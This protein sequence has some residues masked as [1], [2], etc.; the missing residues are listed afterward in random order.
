MSARQSL[1]SGPIGGRIGARV[2]TESA[3]STRTTT[4][5]SKCAPRIQTLG[6]L[7]DAQPFWCNRGDI[8]TADAVLRQSKRR[9]DYARERERERERK[10]E[11]EADRKKERKK[12]REGLHQITETRCT[13]H[14]RDDDRLIENGSPVC[15]DGPRR[16]STMTMTTT[17][18]NR[19]RSTNRC[20]DPAGHHEAGP[21]RHER[22]WRMCTSRAGPDRHGTNRC[23]GN[24]RRSR[25]SVRERPERGPIS[26]EGTSIAPFP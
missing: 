18:T 8:H 26:L 1:I 5:T 14:S 21:I 19:R 22:P 17:K 11:G 24:L 16:T 23:E 13:F 2:N 6:P 15:T 25:E 9:S 10:R 3:A 20:T 7:G 4:T 12:E